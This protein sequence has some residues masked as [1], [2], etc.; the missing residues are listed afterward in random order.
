MK[1]GVEEKVNPVNPALVT[2][3][4]DT[5]T[6]VDKVEDEKEKGE[7]IENEVTENS[8]KEINNDDVIRRRRRGGR[9]RRRRRGGG[10][11]RFSSRAKCSSGRR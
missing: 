9:R 3:P 4:S 8:M 5:N 1:N 6:H 10:R 2:I 7:E 11:R